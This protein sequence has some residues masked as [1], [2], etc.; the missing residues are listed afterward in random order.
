MFGFLQRLR[1]IVPQ[2]IWAA[3][4]YQRGED[5]IIQAQNRTYNNI[6]WNS[7][8]VVTIQANAG[9][10]PIG[11]LV[12]SVLRASRWDAPA[13]DAQGADNPVL[14]AAGAAASV[15]NV[16]VGSVTFQTPITGIAF[17]EVVYPCWSCAVISSVAVP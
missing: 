9:A 3:S 4:V 11:S 6:G 13:P 5:L 17:V 8:P 16:P 15:G 7:E 10:S 1:K 2:N 12:L 14:K